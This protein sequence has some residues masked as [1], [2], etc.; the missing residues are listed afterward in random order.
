MENNQPKDNTGENKALHNRFFEAL[1]D[2]LVLLIAIPTLLGVLL[3][4]TILRKED[5]ENRED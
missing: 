4:T 1:L 3:I 5:R 2:G